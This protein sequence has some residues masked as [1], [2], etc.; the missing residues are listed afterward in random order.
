MAISLVSVKCPD[1][2]ADLQIEEGRE[3]AF[4]AYCGAKVIIH[5]ENEHIIR[6]IDE[7]GIKQAETDRLVML[8]RM[9]LVEKR[10]AE[11]EKTKMFKIV[12][13]LIFVVIGILMM[14]GGTLAGK[15]SGDP[16]SGYYTISMVGM[17]PLIAA[18]WIWIYSKKND[19]DDDD[20]I[21][22]VSGRIPETVVDYNGK[23]FG[24]VV[25]LLNEAG[26]TNVKCVP[27]N[28]LSLGILKKPG[29]VASITVSGKEIRP[30]K[31]YDK[32]ASI[33]ISYHSKQ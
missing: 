5:N 14:I 11:R 18:A 33:V 3:Q 2:G 25:Q 7:A 15:A 4:C 20:I 31:A 22:G 21:L 16:D 9:E 13:S 23:G 10:R 6:T 19:D 30:D 17:F 26:F 12:V 24:A 32:G 8:K 27:L 29:T 1:C 28:D